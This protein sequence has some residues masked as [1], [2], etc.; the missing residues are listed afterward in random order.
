VRRVGHQTSSL[1]LIDAYPL[2]RACTLH[3]LRAHKFKTAQPFADASELLVHGS[4]GAH[5][6][7][8]VIIC[9]GMH[10]V[11]ESALRGQLRLL[12]S[13][14]SSTPLIVMSD[15]EESEEMVA[16]FRE[17]VRGYIPTSLEPCL[18][19]E[20]IRMVLA[21]M[22][23]VPIEALMRVR[24]QSRHK[25]E[26]P[27]REPLAIE[28]RENWPPRQLAVLRLLVQGRPNKEIA[29]ALALD[30]STIKVHVRLIMRKLGVTN[31]TQAAISVRQLETPLALDG[32]PPPIIPAEPRTVA[33]GHLA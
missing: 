10:S 22:S 23:F 5:R 21:D 20:A 25:F 24:R 19:I 29:R 14:L 30:E 3:L 7:S 33:A 11:T 18:V 6:P 8:A 9:T 13:N 27:C 28:H 17:G 12:G 15:L 1:A 31:R 4:I 16:A 2:R 26:R 32:A